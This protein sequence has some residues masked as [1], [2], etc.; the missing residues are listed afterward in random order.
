MEDTF[1]EDTLSI[2]EAV[3]A[4]SAIL[5]A[6]RGFG[7][8]MIGGIK[9]GRLAGIPFYINPS[10]FF[11]FALFTFSLA[12]GHLPSLWPGESTWMYW[13]IGLVSSLLFFGSLL[14]H[15][16]GHSLASLGYGIPVRSITLHLFGGVAQLGREVGRARE[17]FWVAV[18]GPA[19]SLV[20]VGVF[21][22][23][24]RLL[25]TAFPLMRVALEL[26]AVMNAAVLIFNMVPGFPLDGGRVLRSIVWGITGNYRKAT[27]IAAGGGRLFG[28]I[29]ILIGLYLVVAEGRLGALWLA[30]IGWFLMG[31]ARQSYAQAVMQD[32]LQRTPVSE[33]MERLI[34]V[35]GHLTLDEL[36][37]GY[38]NTSG[39]KYFLVEMYGQPVGVILPQMI[40]QIP[41]SQWRETPLFDVMSPLETLPEISPAASA[42]A[43]LYRMEELKAEPLRAVE[44]GYTIGIVTRD[45]LF[46]LLAPPRGHRLRASTGRP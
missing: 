24:S 38:I 16:L 46:G 18:A 11:V 45:R 35:P 36:Y 9:I 39:W 1:M 23:V 25:Y 20:L 13:L 5:D 40:A 4:P 7:V 34:T 15:E 3:L 26:I 42:A 28:M 12:S 27:G 21:W 31:M 8:F 10:W 22:G 17:E 30:F 44:N 29:F 32:K 19:V 14:A 2:V 33:A 43:A 37:A 41:W 6:G